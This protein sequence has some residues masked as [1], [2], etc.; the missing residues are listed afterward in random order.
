MPRLRLAIRQRIGARRRCTKAV[1]EDGARRRCTKTVHEDGARRRC[2]K[3]VHEDGAGRRCTKTVQEGG[4]GRRCAKAVHEGGARRR[5]TKTVH[6]DGARRRSTK[7]VHEDGVRRRCTIF[8]DPSRRNPRSG[9][10]SSTCANRSRSSGERALQRKGGAGNPQFVCDCPSP[11][12]NALSR[13]LRQ[14]HQSTGCS[15]LSR[16]Y[17]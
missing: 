10:S 15:R 8:R 16:Q 7:W 3:T 6:E 11:F 1:H 9:M 2:T 13:F 14:M 17:R 5:C 12:E 4:A